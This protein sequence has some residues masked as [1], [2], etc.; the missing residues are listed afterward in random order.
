[1]KV[2]RY[3]VIVAGNAEDVKYNQ[4]AINDVNEETVLD[5]LKTIK[6]QLK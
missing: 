2:L 3:A 5:T 1:M 6:K 4:F